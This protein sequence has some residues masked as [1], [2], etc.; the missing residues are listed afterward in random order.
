MQFL[1]LLLACGSPSSPP[2]EPSRGE[3]EVR[4]LGEASDSGRPPGCDA[5]VGLEGALEGAVVWTPV[6]GLPPEQRVLSWTDCGPEPA[7][8]VLARGSSL[9]LRNDGSERLAVDWRAEELHGSAVL[10]PGAR[11]S[12]ALPEEGVVG[13]Q[14]GGQRATVVL[15][16]AG[17]VTDAAG[18]A[19]LDA[20]P[21]GPRQLWVLHPDRGARQASV[22]V[23][24]GD[25]VLFEVELR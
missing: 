20:I 19:S 7:G 23:P 6:D 8:L 5:A 9:T 14:A 22:L 18:R 25:R 15:G 24:E 16:G 21:A 1:A 2:H 3:V 11:R 10:A 13:L 12:I 4:V 17:A